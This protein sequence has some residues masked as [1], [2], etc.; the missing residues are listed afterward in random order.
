MARV[1]ENQKL[2]RGEVTNPFAE[3]GAQSSFHLR[4][5]PENT[6]LYPMNSRVLASAKYTGFPANAV[7]AIELASPGTWN[8]QLAILAGGSTLGLVDKAGGVVSLN[9]SGVTNPSGTLMLEFDAGIYY[10]TQGPATVTRY[11]LFSSTPSA[12]TGIFPT[13]Y[14]NVFGTVIPQINRAFF[15]FN[16]SSSFGGGAYV[17]YVTNNV[18]DDTTRNITLLP[19][20][21]LQN[22]VVSADAYKS[23]A[24]FLCT[25]KTGSIAVFY[26][27][28]Y[29]LASLFEPLPQGAPLFIRNVN[30]VLV[31]VTLDS[32]VNNKSL[33]FSVF[34]GERFQV[35]KEYKK[36]NP[37]IFAVDLKDSSATVDD[38][39]LYFSGRFCNEHGLFKY[40]PESNEL[41]LESYYD[42]G[43]I[44]TIVNYG[45]SCAFLPTYKGGIITTTGATVYQDTLNDYN[46]VAPEYITSRFDGGYKNIKKKWLSV[47]INTHTDFGELGSVPA[48]KTITVYYRTDNTVAWTLLGTHTASTTPFTEFAYENTRIT[49][50]DY[51][52]IQFRLVFSGLSYIDEFYV[53]HNGLPEIEN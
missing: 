44:S 4:V 51:Y 7:R 52:T 3:D 50:T 14:T 39:C 33:V 8:G 20:T 1:K 24:V 2:W 27:G 36:F 6:M 29:S 53:T 15:A 26:G 22:E 30:G 42:N 35:V 25:Y 12:V 41:T 34:D 21:E 38:A 17:Y 48:T 31:A 49:I 9:G 16:Y 43:G 13:T 45:N 28:L 5:D 19:A 37:A 40:N 23:Y 47:G 32:N 11:D 10:A 18:F 46:T